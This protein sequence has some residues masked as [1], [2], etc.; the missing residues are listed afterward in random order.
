MSSYPA[1]NIRRSRWQS[2]LA[3]S[4]LTPLVQPATGYRLGRDQANHGLLAK[5]IDSPPAPADQGMPG[6]VVVVKVVGQAGDWHQPIGPSLRQPDEE[7][8]SGYAG[9]PARQDGPH[10]ISQ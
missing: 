2:T 3:A 1:T 6:F 10:P 9:D 5:T 7:A 4:G 8:E